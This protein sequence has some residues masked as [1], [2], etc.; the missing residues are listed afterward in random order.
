VHRDAV[1]AASVLQEPDVVRIQ[2]SAPAAGIEEQ[3]GFEIAGAT[4]D[5]AE[6]LPQAGTT[7]DPQTAAAFVAVNPYQLHAAVARV[8]DDG[9]EL[10]AERLSFELGGGAQQTAWQDRTPC[11]TLPTM[12]TIR[13][14]RLTKRMPDLRLH[15]SGVRPSRDGCVDASPSGTGHSDAGVPHAEHDKAIEPYSATPDRTP[16]DRA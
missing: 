9:F 10:V 7:V 6:Q 2:G 8:A 4:F 13:V 12:P 5:I 15:R 11:P 14:R 16:M 3:D 1:L